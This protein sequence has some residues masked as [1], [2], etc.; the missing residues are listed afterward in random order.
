MDLHIKGTLMVTNSLLT[1]HEVKLRYSNNMARV[2]SY[3]AT[4]LSWWLYI[5]PQCVGGSK[6]PA[7]C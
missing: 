4:L 6:R 3:V 7:G 2:H 5:I 1:V